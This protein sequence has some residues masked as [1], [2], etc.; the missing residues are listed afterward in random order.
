MSIFQEL[1]IEVDRDD[2]R[3][4]VLNIL[5][6]IR[7][8]WKKEEICITV[9]C[10]RFCNYILSLSKM[11]VFV[12]F[13]LKCYGPDEFDHSVLLLINMSHYIKNRVFCEI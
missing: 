12:L 9:G 8:Q 3:P 10:Y 5:A 13:T 11:I 7:P 4:A 1:D 6:A 2:Y